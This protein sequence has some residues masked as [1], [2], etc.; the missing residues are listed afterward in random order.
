MRSVSQVPHPGVRHAGA[1]AVSRGRPGGSGCGVGV[2]LGLDQAGLLER[3]QKAIDEADR[4]QAQPSSPWPGHS[5][6]PAN[7][8]AITGG[9]LMKRR[10]CGRVR[11]A[12]LPGTR[13]VASALRAQLRTISLYVRLQYRPRQFACLATGSP[14]SEQSDRMDG[15]LQCR[16]AVVALLLA[17]ASL[18]S[19][20]HAPFPG[21]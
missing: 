8:G 13:T 20:A 14:R 9:R 7:G 17:A 5:R 1:S 15:S 2:P 21:L 12:D 18:G 16:R 19:P 11:R 4:R 3:P 6:N 10:R